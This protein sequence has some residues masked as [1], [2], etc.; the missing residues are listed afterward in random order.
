MTPQ[1]TAPIST[2]TPD[3]RN[4]G[5]IP[6]TRC[7]SQTTTPAGKPGKK[8]IFLDFAGV[9]MTLRTGDRGS[10]PREIE[11]WL[12]AHPEVTDYRILDDEDHLWT[13]IQRQKWLQCD[14]LNGL[15]A[16]EMNCLFEWAGL[17]AFSKACFE[18][19]RAKIEPPS[20]DST[21]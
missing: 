21:L 10:R 16:E 11:D 5:S 4:V 1:Q 17:K 3:P 7:P 2:Q 15:Q 8:I 19:Q 18:P 13:D 20:S 6:I 9:L 14:P 12:A